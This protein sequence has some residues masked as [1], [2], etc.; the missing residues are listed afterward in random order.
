MFFKAIGTELHSGSRVLFPDGT[1][2]SSD[3]PPASPV[4][5]WQWFAGEN[6]ARAALGLPTRE[7]THP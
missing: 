6:E 2:L 7:E 4:D 1:E 5:G 3:N